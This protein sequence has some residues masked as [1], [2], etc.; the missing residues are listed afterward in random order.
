[1]NRRRWSMPLG[2]IKS[3]LVKVCFEVPPE[4]MECTGWP[5]NW[6]HFCIRLHLPNT[7]RFSKLFHCQNQEKIYNNTIAKYPTVGFP[8]HLIC[9]ATLP[10]KISSVLKSTTENKTTSEVKRPTLIVTKCFIN[11]QNFPKYTDQ[12]PMTSMMTSL[13]TGKRIIK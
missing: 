10:C 6:H 12:M 9:V 13:G 5:K 7:N 4:R 8:P 11:K 2:G 3:C 1:M